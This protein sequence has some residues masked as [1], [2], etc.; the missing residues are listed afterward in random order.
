M[1]LEASRAPVA[2]EPINKVKILPADDYGKRNVCTE[3]EKYTY[4]N[5]F[6]I[7]HKVM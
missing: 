5:T 2:V 3:Y 7:D 1:H 4:I 6:I